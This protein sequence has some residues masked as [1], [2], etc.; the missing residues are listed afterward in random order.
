[1]YGCVAVYSILK[2]CIIQSPFEIK[3]LDQN[4]NGEVSF[5]HID[6]SLITAKCLSFPPQVDGKSVDIGHGCVTTL[7]AVLQQVTLPDQ[8]CG[9]QF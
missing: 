6:M 5:E 3:S 4:A 2:F 7:G 1:L 8:D 9:G